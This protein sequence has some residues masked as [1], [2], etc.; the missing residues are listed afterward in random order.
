M[1]IFKLNPFWA[2]SRGTKKNRLCRA[3]PSTIQPWSRPSRRVSSERVLPLD[4]SRHPIII[5]IWRHLTS[6]IPMIVCKMIRIL[7]TM[8]RNC[9]L[10]S[11]PATRSEPATAEAKDDQNPPRAPSR[12][13]TPTPRSRLSMRSTAPRKGERNVLSRM[14][15]LGRKGAQII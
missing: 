7:F 14:A 12:S 9:K 2:P 6:R 13:S 11:R 15:L 4:R 10:S 5:L 3:R 1:M 8:T